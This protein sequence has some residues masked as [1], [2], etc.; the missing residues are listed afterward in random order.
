MIKALA[1][2]LGGK[3]GPEMIRPSSERGEITVAKSGLFLKYTSSFCPSC[4]AKRQVEAATHLVD[5]VLPMAPYRQFVVTFPIPMRY[6]LHSNKELFSKVYRIIIKE[7]HSYY[8]TKALSSG[9]KDPKS[10][11]ISFTQL[12]G[13]ALNLN[14][15]A[16]LKNISGRKVLSQI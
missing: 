14:P 16:N 5:H 8:K 10:G 1:N 4:C 13:S 7:I 2:V 15:R 6:W 3:L 12:A 9:I 11:A